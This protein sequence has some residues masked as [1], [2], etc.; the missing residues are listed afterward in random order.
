MNKDES[1]VPVVPPCFVFL[2]KKSHRNGGRY[3]RKTSLHAPLIATHGA[4]FF[5]PRSFM[6][7]G[8]TVKLPDE[9]FHLLAN[10]LISVSIL[11]SVEEIPINSPIRFYSTRNIV[12]H[13]CQFSR[14]QS[15]LESAFRK[16]L[17][18]YWRGDRYSPLAIA[19]ITFYIRTSYAPSDCCCCGRTLFK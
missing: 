5:T 4:L 10:S 14:I 16:I 3:V 18:P 6:R 2:H 15:T 19:T 1:F 17:F 7:S 12:Y 13:T 11:L 8:V 9:T